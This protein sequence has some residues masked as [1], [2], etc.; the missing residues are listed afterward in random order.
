MTTH[1]ARSD[2][3][4]VVGSSCR[5]PGETTCP[6]KFWHLL[7]KPRDVRSHIS[8]AGR[9][10]VKGFYHKQGN[11]HG[12]T[13]VEHAYLCEGD[14]NCFDHDFFNIHRRE[15]EAMDPQQK[16]LL[17]SVYEGID[18]AGYSM[19]D[20]RGSNTGVF[21]GQMT[22]DHKE[23][24][25]RDMDNIPHYTATG[26]S[27]AVTANRVSYFFDWRGPSESLDTACSS[28][29]VALH[30]AVQ[31]LRNG[32]ITMAIAAGVNLISNPDLFIVES[33]LQMLSPTGR[34]HMWDSRADGYARGEGVAV[35]ILK[36]LHQALHDKDHIECVI[37]ET[38]VNQNGRTVG[39]LTVPNA[40]AQTQ[41]IQSTYAKCGLDPTV[42]RDRCQFFEAHGTGTPAGDPRE[43]QAIRDA[44]FPLQKLPQNVENDDD[45][46][47]QV[48]SVKT[49][50]GH[51]EGAAGLVAVL[52]ASL[53]LQN[54]R[55][56]PN[57][58][59]EQ[60]N[61]AVAP[62]YDPHLRIPTEAKPWPALEPG[63]P[64]RASVNSFGLGGTNAHV[65]LESWDSAE[66]PH[67]P[68]EKHIC[69]LYPLSASS[70]CALEKAVSK[71]AVMLREATDEL[72]M[73]DLAWT[74]QNRRTEFR[75]RAVFSAATRL[76]L[77]GKLERYRSEDS[78]GGSMI[79][80]SVTSPLQILG[81]FTGQGAQWLGM[82]TS[83]YEQSSTF[84]RS[85][86]SL[87]VSLSQLPDAPPWS[88]ASRLGPGN[89][90]DGNI[91]DA[92]IAQPLTTALQI[93]LVD[94]LRGSGIILNAVI[95]HSSGEIAAAYASGYL[96]ATDAIRLAYYRG[97]HSSAAGSPKNGEPGS[98]MAAALPMRDAF[99]FCQR[100]DL[101]GKITIAASNSPGNVT[102]SGDQSAIEAAKG[103]L[104]EMGVFARVLRVNKA[105][106][107]HHMLTCKDVYLQSIQRCGIG[108]KKRT[109]RDGCPWYSSLYGS[110]GSI[111]QN[112]G[113]LRDTYWVENLIKPVL[114]DQAVDRAVREFDRCFDIALEIGPHPVLRSPFTESFKA[115]T[116]VVIPYIGVLKR[117]L[118]DTVAFSDA[119]GS[120][121]ARFQ[122]KTDVPS[123]VN[124][125]AFRQTLYGSDSEQSSPK[126]LTNL[127]RYSWDHQ[128]PT[129]FESAK[130]KAR[131]NYGL[132]IH[133]LLGKVTQY[134][135]SNYRDPVT[136]V[137]RNVLRLSEI[138]FLRGHQFQSQ[139]IFPAAGYVSMAID[140]CASVASALVPS[141]HRPS[142]MVELTNLNFHR[143]ITISDD[144]S[145]GVEVVFVMRVTQLDHTR[146]VITAEYSCYSGDAT[147]WLDGSDLTH[148][149]GALTTTSL[150]FDGQ[151]SITLS[152]VSDEQRAGRAPG[153]PPRAAS[154]MPLNMVDPGRFYSWASTIGLQYSGLFVLD[155]IRRRRNLSTV[156]VKNPGDDGQDD[157]TV[158]HIHPAALDAAF[159]GIFAAHSFPGDGRLD[160]PYLP[161]TI[162]RIQIDMT[163]S[164]HGSCL[165][166]H[167][168]SCE[169]RSGLI[170]DCYVR[171]DAVSAISGDVNL[172]CIGCDCPT[173]Q[174]E[175]L[176]VSRLSTNTE[177]SHRPLFANTVWGRDLQ[178]SGFES[179]QIMVD[180]SFP[181]S[182][183]KLSE[184]CD[185]MSFFYLR[186]LASQLSQ[187][188]VQSMAWHF[189]Y[190]LDWVVNQLTPSVEAGRHSRVPK[191][192]MTDDASLIATEVE[193]FANCI[194]VQLVQ[195]VGENLSS[196]MRASCSER[197]TAAAS[198]TSILELLMENDKLTRFYHHAAGMWHANQL[199][200]I[201]IGQLAHR[202]PNMNII[203]VGGG[204]GAATAPALSQLGGHF[205]SYIF[206]DI[207]AA[208][209]HDAK[210]KFS[211]VSGV[212]NVQFVALDIERDP[213]ES[214]FEEHTF[215]LVIASNVLHATASLAN[216]IANCRK[217]LKP[218]GFLI[219]AELTSETLYGRFI[220]SG[221]PGWWLGREG[222]GRKYGP[223]V[224]EERWDDLLKHVGFTGLDHVM[225]D[226]QDNSVYLNSVMI[227]QATDEYVDFLRTP[228]RLA[229][230]STVKPRLQQLIIVDDRDDDTQCLEMSNLLKAFADHIG[231]VHGL[232]TLATQPL[233]N[234]TTRAQS[235]I[236]SRRGPETAVICLTEPVSD[237]VHYSTG[238]SAPRQKALQNIVQYAS[239]IF[240]VTIGDEANCMANV[241]LGIAR[242]VMCE[243]PHIRFL[244]LNMEKSCDSLPRHFS[245]VSFLSEI[246]LR[247]ILLEDPRCGHVLWTN[248]TELA[249]R[250]D[251]SVYIP[252]VKP[253]RS[254]N[255]WLACGYT[256]AIEE[257]PHNTPIG[258]GPAQVRHGALRQAG[259]IPKMIEDLQERDI[260][261]FETKLSTLLSFTGDGNSPVYLCIGNTP[262]RPQQVALGLSEVVSSSM[263]LPGD[264]VLSLGSLLA[265]DILFK[266]H[267]IILH[268]IVTVIVCED[269]LSDLN[270]I[271][272]VHEAPA[273]MCQVMTQL[274]EIRGLEVFL[275]T[276]SLQTRSGEHFESCTFIHPRTSKRALD[277]LIPAGT[278][279]LA[280]ATP[281]DDEDSMSFYNTVV[282]S[283]IVSMTEIR[284]LYR[285]M[286]QTK[287]FVTK[288]RSGLLNMV[289]RELGIFQ[290][291]LTRGIESSAHTPAV[292]P[293]HE[294]N[295]VTGS[296]LVTT[297]VEWD[298]AEGRG[299]SFR[300]D[301][302]TFPPHRL[303]SADKTYLLVGLAGEVGMSLVEW[304]IG[305]GGRHFAIVSRNPQIHPGVRTHLERL[306]MIEMRTWAVDVADREAL[307][308]AHA[309]IMLSMPPIAGVANGAMVLRDR[310]FE[311][312]TVKDF[313][314]V[315]RPK[316]QGTRH[317]D[318]LFRSDRELEFFVLFASG[319]S[320]VGNAG[321]ANYSA[322]NMYMASVAAERQKRGVAAS[323]IYLGQILGVGHVA[324]SLLLSNGG[325]TTGT[326]E[327]Q[328]RRVSS[329]PL[330]ET[331]LHA[332]FAAAIASGRPGSDLDHEIVVGLGDGKQ[333]P[334]R[335]IPRFSCWTSSMHRIQSRKALA[336][337]IPEKSLPQPERLPGAS[338]RRELGSLLLSSH[339]DALSLLCDHFSS[340][341][342]VI[343]Q[344]DP[345]RVGRTTPLISL[346][347]DSLVAVEVRS[348]FLK[349]LSVEIP[350]LGMLNGGSLADLCQDALT[351]FAAKARKAKSRDHTPEPSTR[352]SSA[353]AISLTQ[354][355]RDGDVDT[356]GIAPS[357]ASARA[358]STESN[359]DHSADLSP[360]TSITESLTQYSRIG[361][362]SSAQARLYFLHQYLEEKSPYTIG[363][364]GKFTGRL[365]LARL[366]S[367]LRSVQEA[368]ESLRSC[369]YMEE[370][371]NRTVQAVLPRPV[372]GCTHVQIKNQSKVW[373]EIERQKSHVFD[374]EHGE[375]LRVT[376][377]SRSPVDH[378]IIFLHHHIAMDGVGWFLFLRQLDQAYQG[379]RLLQPSQQSID[380]SI[381]QKTFDLKRRHECLGHWR[382][383]YHDAHEPLPL[384]P[385]AKVKNRQIL[386]RYDAE[387]LYLELD[388]D[389]SMRV[390]E[391]SMVL[392]V[393]PFHFYLSALAVLLI[394]CLGIADFSIGIVD[395]NRPDGED[396]ETMGYFLNMLPLRFGSLF[397]SDLKENMTLAHLVQAVRDMSLETL[398]QQRAPFDAILDSL[399]VSRAGS[400]HPLFQVALDYR[401]GYTVKQGM[402]GEGVMEW[403][404]KRSITARNPYDIFVNITPTAK[405]RTFVHWT[406]QKYMY[407]SSDSKL[408]MKWYV[409]I[410]DAMAREPS[411]SIAQCP[412]A[413]QE[414]L[415]SA[416]K[417]GNGAERL[418]HP[419][420]PDWSNGTIIHQIDS[421]AR[422]HAESTALID[423]D[424]VRLTY[425]ELMDRVE[426]ISRL[427]NGTMATQSHS[428][429]QDTESPAV[430]AVI[431]TLIHPT[432]DYVCCLL[433]VLR[434]GYTCIGLDLRNPEERLG[435]MLSDCRPK[436]LI[437]NDQ[438]IDLASRL[439]SLISAQV[440]NLGETATSFNKSQTIFEEAGI[441]ENKSQMHEC[442]VILYTSG[443]TGVP[444]GV[445]LTHQNLH[446]HIKANSALYGIN[447][448]DVILQQTSPGFD[449]SLDQIFHALANGGRLVIANREQRADPT[450]LSRLLVQHGVTITVGCPSEY[451]SL[452]S[453]EVATL[454]QCHTWRLAFSGGE[455]L[456]FQLRKGFQNLGLE[457]LNLVNVYGP[458][459]VTIACAR[460]PMPY[461][462]EEDL[463][464]QADYLFPMPGY[465]ILVVD[466]DMNLVPAGFP[467]EI[468]I[469]GDGVTLGYLNRPD[470]TNR[471]FIE[472][473]LDS[474]KAMLSSRVAGAK[475]PH[476]TSVQVV[477]RSYTSR[478]RLYRSGDY[479]RL[480]DNG[481]I[482]LLGRL[483]SSSQVK[484]RGMRVELD[485]VANAIIHEAAGALASAVVSLRQGPPET[486][487]AFVLFEGHYQPEARRLA[488]LQRIKTSLPL[489]AHMRP[490]MIVPI[491]KL[492]INVN[493]KLDRAAVDKL[494]IPK[495]DERGGELT[496]PDLNGNGSVWTHTELRMKSV[497][498]EVFH[499]TH[500]GESIQTN[501]VDGASTSPVPTTIYAGSD[502][503]QVGGNSLSAIKLRNI[504]QKRFHV[505][506]PLPE[507]F[508]LRTVANM[509]ARI[510][511]MTR[512]GTESLD[513]V[514]AASPYNAKSV[515]K[516]PDWAAEVAILCDG[517]TLPPF[518]PHI[519]T[520]SSSKTQHG[521][522][523]ILLTG[524]TGFLGSRLLHLLVTDPRVTQVHCVAVRERRR[525]GIASDDLFS[526]KKVSIHD[527]DLTFPRLGLTESTFSKFASTVDVIIHNGAKVSFLE[528]YGDA[529]RE[530]NVVAT[531]TVCNLALQRRVPLHFIST[532]NVAR[533]LGNT[534]TLDA[535][536]IA[537][538]MP[539]RLDPAGQQELDGYT[540][541]KWVA[542]AV[543]HH[544]AV[545]HGLPVWVHRVASLVGPD[546]PDHDFVGS[547]LRYSNALGAVPRFE[548]P[549]AEGRGLQLYGSLDLL[550]VERVAND[551]MGIA[552]ESS[553]SQR[554][555]ASA[556]AA[557]PKST[558][559]FIH[560]CNEV[561]DRISPNDIQ[562]YMED[563]HGR[564]FTIVGMDHWLVA[565]KEQ[566]LPPV[567]Y[568][569]LKEMVEKGERVYFPSLKKSARQI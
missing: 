231:I 402:F 327:A 181:D 96:S 560:H 435:V 52:K 520:A 418:P 151:A 224:T 308:Q 419:H 349:E 228:L 160:A 12:S 213:A 279:R 517:L 3:I 412:L 179:D 75:F 545:E 295:S 229:A 552:L 120:I 81:V 336:S 400:H 79:Q 480:L 172:F 299:E 455:K 450:H 427:I 244:L 337:Q 173:M 489:P 238:M 161:S 169:G 357:A 456:T 564:P 47:L 529:L 460:G 21:L 107:S 526:A 43:A 135:G 313:E 162:D 463:V 124:W 391:K 557:L 320:I 195:T 30:H 23:L 567:M 128:N 305:V 509:A 13:N 437:C 296:R 334:W 540:L 369:Y 368:H 73:R 182:R 300:K 422:Q 9:F 388:G 158:M 45:G 7:E 216:T 240:W 1:G 153:L 558:A 203:E 454:R 227:T 111:E 178:S 317:L 447:N 198:P 196:I 252:R 394:R 301:S 549:G 51:S 214:G 277:T 257:A 54:A 405:D 40:H 67:V 230:P 366:Q 467:G 512:A 249:M 271:L 430:K 272:W 534:T 483:G 20:L 410:L 130:S 383:I 68:L 524:A 211:S 18:A 242:T 273:E 85:I 531:R 285:D 276:S 441:V 132:S 555:D 331:D 443:S 367:S 140:A 157:Q 544:A 330:S 150:R 139:V 170:A 478:I 38:G 468:C 386:K 513:S 521:G 485:E 462:T 104:D 19:H 289:S 371:S 311:N 464:G 71:L 89:C 28:S 72:N 490:T 35:L 239:H 379:K 527:G 44:F 436:I 566:G 341:L 62:F 58:H 259:R 503:F 281:G 194:E 392:G 202:H 365:D 488:L 494:P 370:S 115:A 451:M 414:D 189:Q 180:S 339:G 314:T 475:E 167:S 243:S 439:G 501:A 409:R 265:S 397:R 171:N 66:E 408:M 108:V 254:L 329:L 553:G 505:V 538:S 138:D 562:V 356:S 360:T 39:G 248:E 541:S 193:P 508:R 487:V 34:C 159:H 42:A 91:D 432:T 191:S 514:C 190:L 100:P 319:T 321:Q 118:D 539:P 303:L 382:K 550:P 375:V 101:T 105:Y 201:A 288:H 434:L 233:A 97:L 345:S 413:T 141:V 532:A 347:I 354:A 507:L 506:I 297:I 261:L 440:L 93:S 168:S 143:A 326:V 16:V 380:L 53:A 8:K 316:V 218:G 286:E 17:E 548:T 55:I 546:A 473:S 502:F 493:G 235:S 48:G 401:Q 184:V 561:T 486:L 528:P 396:G 411:K 32:D 129:Y 504:I 6:S 165:Q 465:G 472:A 543:L 445:L 315:F 266:S 471:N 225:R 210:Q 318:D 492:P 474:S 61:P 144:F 4:A 264:Q 241:V 236:S 469:T 428:S 25:Y 304:M 551:V 425:R 282:R 92:E 22:D 117:G 183:S 495:G 177:E 24:L 283:G 208:F 515:S 372:L 234:T 154:T 14:Q 255:R 87:D 522:K 113:E 215:D 481:S 27:R 247:M 482:H 226:T 146:H 245:D 298:H 449:F 294:M 221:L 256:K 310:P 342:G 192:W 510:D 122:S 280:I 126:L 197:E 352:D 186:Q 69:N 46:I 444:K 453:N 373:H 57:M 156:T 83:L 103:L 332:S 76:D 166:N 322:A 446:S 416:I 559:I 358:L 338:L 149:A 390:K 458:T 477:P 377:M 102:L 340:Q 50:V 378:Y 99:I 59:F 212:E 114:F 424:G 269:L 466:E 175:G 287:I 355:G 415:K 185:R 131:R 237:E 106:H 262:T 350:I 86:E 346:G 523:V 222:D 426:H 563:T 125:D 274:A 452:L 353:I 363:Y 187:E 127:P 84:R 457:K 219:L 431:G 381:K 343:L 335:S 137:W 260:V 133:P 78:N 385:F 459:E 263:R 351:Q 533:V 88:L 302:T 292:I 80:S 348:W 77:L 384:F 323:V 5:L 116:G 258:N 205:S 293:L 387:T 152:H 136:M 15:A 74:L 223:M 176:T 82:G 309:D 497:W 556:S 374:I 11:Y 278:T 37:R 479:G 110:N 232:E 389:L 142:R 376:V 565:A 535:V 568:H 204:T 49:V 438:T 209:F 217:L 537:G 70:E 290:Q 362:M 536:S 29:L 312:M 429:H 56:P 94:L 518:S 147:A 403:D 253:N 41:L 174:I 65:I 307:Y 268:H 63:V 542:E 421:T 470:E 95:G 433:A 148:E 206:T 359:S 417:L 121:W 306:G 525:A 90:R 145:A 516:E 112:P 484:I 499:D 220:V 328:L 188:E 395:A 324:R 284:Q 164:Y 569:Y 207:S 498:R 36:P 270:G 361:E 119:I 109:S 344:M 333:A 33:K 200:G 98:M 554:P 31:A 406:T 442:A 491:Q 163:D 496:S 511:E 2:A 10:N 155:S 547:L 398:T 251:G 275:S 64:R 461:R 393:T 325:G 199:V 60:L 399:E 519:A 404:I 267:T 407:S 423:G 134:G 530:P 291:R 123:P 420:I 476:G 364:V 26:A 500:G 246:F 250:A 448:D